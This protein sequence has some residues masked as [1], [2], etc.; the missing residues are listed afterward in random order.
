MDDTI[1]LT[2]ADIQKII[3]LA[4][5]AGRE[6]KFVYTLGIIKPYLATQGRDCFFAFNADYKIS[7]SSDDPV[8]HVFI[9]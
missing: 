8:P 3:M 7:A 4:Q 9:T 5:N 6:G 2:T 1:Y